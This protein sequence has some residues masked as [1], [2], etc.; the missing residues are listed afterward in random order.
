MHPITHLLVGWTLANAAGLGKRD[1]MLVTVAGVIPDI[2]GLGVL[3]DVLTEH[4]VHPLI[5][6]DRFHHVLAHNALFGLGLTLAALALA[7]RRGLTPLLVLL[8]FHLHLLGD[9]VGS[10]GP[11]GYQWPIPYL[12][13]FS[14][15]WQLTWSHQWGLMAWPNVSFTVALLALTLH[16]AWKRGRSP[17]ELISARA[18]AALTEALR[19]RFGEPAPALSP[20]TGETPLVSP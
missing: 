13:P 18:D 7:R 11:E 1:R 4:S 9:I 19:A 8:S 10:R 17:L 16:G 20:A 12:L 2:D 15:A 14:A 5:L 3:A 6:Y